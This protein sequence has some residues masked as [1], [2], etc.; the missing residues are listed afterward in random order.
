MEAGLSPSVGVDYHPAAQLW[1]GNPQVA[2]MSPFTEGGGAESSV[3]V[4]LFVPI[5]GWL[6]G[7]L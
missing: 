5:M 1:L 7:H 4:G 6:V 3:G 2:S